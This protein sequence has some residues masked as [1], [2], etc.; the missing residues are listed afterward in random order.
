MPEAMAAA[1]QTVVT[2]TTHLGT[3]VRLERA[4][5]GALFVWER[6]AVPIEETVQ[7]LVT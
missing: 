3:R 7:A 2:A 4:R 5:S 1:Q 6:Q